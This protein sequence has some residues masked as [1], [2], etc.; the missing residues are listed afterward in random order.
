MIV[1][2]YN[3]VMTSIKDTTDKHQAYLHVLYALLL[4]HAVSAVLYLIRVWA[5]GNYRYGFLLWNV[6]LGWIPLLF[7]WLLIRRLPRTR[8]SSAVNIALSVAWLGFLPN[9]FYLVSDLIHLR[10][11]GEVSLLYDA[12]LFLSCIF[13]GYV[14]GFASL[15]LLHHEVLRR[16][17]RIQSHVWV[18]GVLLACGFAIYLGRYLRWNSW[19]VLVNPFGI[20]FDLSDRAINP[21]AY[22]QLFS[23]TFTFFVLLGSMYIVLWQFMAAL[24]ITRRK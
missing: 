24:T 8:W 22:P 2:A 14:A 13:N 6:F 11:T 5:A 19:D 15:Y 1:S 23:T 10:S 9:S 16:L 4:S 18:A 3:S 20:L 17:G 7:A 21:L 12:V